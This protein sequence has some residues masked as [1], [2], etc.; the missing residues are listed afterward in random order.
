MFAKI[1]QRGD[2]E[3]EDVVFVDVD[4]DHAVGGWSHL[5]AIPAV[6]PPLRSPPAT[7]CRLSVYVFSI[8]TSVHRK[9]YS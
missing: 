1:L 4:D 8:S 7:D 5:E 6:A 2:G 3:D 9:E